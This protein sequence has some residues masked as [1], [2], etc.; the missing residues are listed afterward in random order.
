MLLPKILFNWVRAQ[1]A[2]KAMTLSRALTNLELVGSVWVS[3]HLS[4]VQKG[5]QSVGMDGTNPL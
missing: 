1:S 3:D 4:A 2:G 5:A